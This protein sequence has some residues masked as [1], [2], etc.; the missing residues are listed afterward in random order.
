VKGDLTQLKQVLT[1][2]L[3]NALKFTSAGFVKLKVETLLNNNHQIVQVRFGVKDSGIGIDE[4]HI[5]KIFESFTQADAKTTR[6]FGGTG[7]GLTISA[8]L[9]ELMGGKLHVESER[10][11][12]S[13]F[14]FDLPFETA[15]H[16]HKQKED[17]SF[18]ELSSFASMRIL[19][20][21]D[22]VVNQLVAKRILEKWNI[23][24]TVVENGQ[25]ALD[26]MAKQKFDMVLMDLE[27]PVMDG[28][29]AVKEIRKTDIE[30]P[31]IAF[32]AASYE[33]MKADLQSKGLNDFVQKPF[34][35]EALHQA[36]VNLVK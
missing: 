28:L 25:K 34:K 29:T 18:S 30:L 20:A 23:D 21:E 14:W 15:V 5:H 9:I 36:I 31:I 1:N 32:T 26:E 7:L 11:K 35:P 22:N 24:V 8:K 3:S 2:L 17:I 19:V 4:K 27:M 16:L 12:G 33:N 13:H 6:K 10:N